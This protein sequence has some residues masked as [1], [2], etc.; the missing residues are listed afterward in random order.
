MSDHA[1][2]RE[3]RRCTLRALAAVIC[4]A[5][6]CGFMVLDNGPS[7]NARQMLGAVIFVP[8]ALSTIGSLLLLVNLGCC[9]V[10]CARE[11][12]VRYLMAELPLRVITGRQRPDAPA[13][14]MLG[15]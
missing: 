2:S 4:A 14:A 3:I 11:G 13:D 5:A 7:T 12:G 8:L 9:L 6:C 1:W 10:A 15:G